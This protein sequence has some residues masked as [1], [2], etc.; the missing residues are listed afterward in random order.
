MPAITIQGFAGIVPR[1]H[2]RLIGDNQAQVAMN[3]VL[4]NGQIQPLRKPKFA[5]DPDVFEVK[6]VF[7]MIKDGLE[8]WVAWD[9]DVNVE[10]GQ[11]L[12]D[13]LQRIYWTGD[14]EPRMSTYD[15]VFG[16]FGPYPGGSGS[17]QFVLGVFPPETA[18]TVGHTG[19][20]GADVS[21][22]FAYTF[23]TPLGEE[24]QPSPPTTY[25]G[26]VDAT[27][28][29]ITDMDVAPLNT[30][31]VVGAA[32]ATGTATFE[33][34]STFGLRV[35]EEIEV[36][37]T[38]P[39]GYDV[40]GPI[41]AIPD[42]THVSIAITDDPGAYVSDGDIDRIAL[43]NT[44]G[45][46]KRIYAT[47]TGASGATSFRLWADEVPIGDTTYDDAYDAAVL[48][49][50]SPLESTAFEMPPTDMIALRSLPNGIVAGLSGKEVCLCEP[51]RPHAW[52]SEYR[53]TVKHEGVGLGSFGTTLVVLT[54]GVPYTISGVEPQ[55]MGGGAVAF[56]EAWPCE[57]KRGIVS[58]AAGV[59]WPAPQGLA[60]IGYAGAQIVTREFF[61][62]K[63]WAQL[64]PDTFIS[65]VCD[66]RYYASYDDDSGDRYTIIIDRSEFAAVVLAN[67]PLAGLWTN[68]ESGKLYV[69]VNDE[70]LEWDS[71]ESDTAMFDWMSK[72][73]MSAPP[74]NFGAAKIDGDFTMTQADIAIQQA[75]YDAVVADN[76]DLIDNGLVGASMAATPI[77]YLPLAG[78]LM[79]PTPSVQTQSL[80]FQLIVDDEVKHYQ[81]VINNK[82]FKLPGGYKSDNVT[83]RV[84]G[85]VR[86][87]KVAMAGNI[88]E[89]RSI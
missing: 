40:R 85:N 20:S 3:C 34:A 26:K 81:Q 37:G 64:N 80:A 83:V 22:S 12:G 60:M 14:Y 72:E 43:H 88:N 10:P 79:D 75:A 59:L 53:Q 87:T 73:F 7:R 16:G 18:P 38:D 19:G 8:N 46:F 77:G 61:T 45:M 56:E 51:Y 13:I 9:K 39:V 63:E 33:V 30:M 15:D 82:P 25:T 36:T 52:P 27:S 55:S 84:T 69:I 1:I 47:I 68:P 62:L 35:G 31:A 54:T 17:N 89:L 71:P 2:R 24:S 48:A 76:Q 67:Y 23:V 4:T 57:S 70:V 5:H 28:W 29:D 44:T 41:T 49:L 6:T 78:D 42:A 65:A 11:V 21:V 50:S 74:V 86:V 32:W 66:N 58:T